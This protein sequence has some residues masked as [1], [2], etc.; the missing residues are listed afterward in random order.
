MAGTGDPEAQ[1]EM[2]S[3]V[4]NHASTISTQVDLLHKAVRA[5]NPGPPE[6]DRSGVSA[7]RN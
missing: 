1:R 5:F 2:A 3:R 4:L 7:G 6:I